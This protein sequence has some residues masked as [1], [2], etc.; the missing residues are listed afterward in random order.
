MVREGFLEKGALL[1]LGSGL[2]T[3]AA[4]WVMDYWRES[5]AVRSVWQC[6]REAMKIF[7]RFRFMMIDRVWVG[8]GR[9][10]M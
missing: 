7:W 10:K 6:A 9:R 4:L 2:V 5:P 3:L 8:A 1:D